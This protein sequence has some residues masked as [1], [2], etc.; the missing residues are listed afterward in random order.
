MLEKDLLQ[1]FQ[2]GDLAVIT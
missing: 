1:A 2:D